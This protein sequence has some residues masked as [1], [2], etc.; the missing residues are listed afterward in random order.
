[1]DRTVFLS[2]AALGLAF[3]ALYGVRCWRDSAPVDVGVLVNIMLQSGGIV[4]GAFLILSTIVPQLKEQ[5]A[6]LDIYILISGI[7]VAS[8]SAQGLKRAVWTG[9]AVG[10]A[11]SLPLPQPVAVPVIAAA[12]D[13][14]TVG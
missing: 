10:P 13:A 2:T 11:P 1:M 7:A 6:T 9:K 14:R 5:L 4:A 12:Q 8:V 3:I